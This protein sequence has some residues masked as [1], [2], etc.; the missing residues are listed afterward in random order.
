MLLV[1]EV[2]VFVTDVAVDVELVTVVEVFVPV[3]VDEVFVFVVPVVDVHEIVVELVFVT[4]VTEV[5]VQVNV[6][7]VV[8]VTVLDVIDVPVIVV[9]VIVELV[10]VCVVKVLDVSD[11]VVE[12]LVVVN[13]GPTTSCNAVSFYHIAFCIEFSAHTTGSVAF[14]QPGHICYAKSSFPFPPFSCNHLLHKNLRAD[15]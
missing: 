2:L 11:V 1:T 12:V 9:C 15:V 3:I 10:F 14:T 5:D 13:I 4:L 7:E 8:F 6:V